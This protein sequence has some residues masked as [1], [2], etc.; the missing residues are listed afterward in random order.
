MFRVCEVLIF[1]LK[2]VEFPLPH[3]KPMW[4]ISFH[5]WLYITCVRQVWCISTVVVTQ[6]LKFYQK[7]LK[8][9]SKNRRRI[10]NSFLLPRHG[11]HM[12]I[13]YK[14]YERGVYTKPAV[15]VALKDGGGCM[16]GSGSSLDCGTRT[17]CSIP[18]NPR[19]ERRAFLGVLSSPVLGISLPRL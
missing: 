9:G 17:M 19:L 4:L 15:G 5:F 1:I 10:C 3:A 7:K 2:P 12:I 18:S 16:F 11:V 8:I 14:I 6:T 13:R